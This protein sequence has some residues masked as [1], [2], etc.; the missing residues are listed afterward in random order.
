MHHQDMPGTS[1]H[2]LVSCAVKGRGKNHLI[3]VVG[4]L[5][6]PATEL[7]AS[8]PAVAVPSPPI[9][10]AVPT[11]QVPCPPSRYCLRAGRSSKGRRIASS[12]TKRRRAG[13]LGLCKVAVACRLWW[14]IQKGL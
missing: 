7:T 13:V 6:V 5:K 14:E 12:R 11:A 4:C 8:P 2:R 10:P 1:T 9:R 3:D